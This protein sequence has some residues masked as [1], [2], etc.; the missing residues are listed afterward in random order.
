MKNKIK[1]VSL[2]L[3]LLTLFGCAEKPLQSSGESSLQN[4]EISSTDSISSLDSEATESTESVDENWIKGKENC[5]TFSY[6]KDNY[7][8]TNYYYETGESYD[9]YGYSPY[10]GKTFAEFKAEK[11]GVIVK[12]RVAGDSYNAVLTG[13]SQ[14]FFD[15]SDLETR[16]SVTVGN[17]VN[18]P[19]YFFY[20]L[21]P[22][23]IE[24]IVDD[25]IYGTSIKVGEVVYVME[26]YYK[27]SENVIQI[28]KNNGER[29][30][31]KYE[32]FYG[33]EIA[34]LHEEQWKEKLDLHA[35]LLEN[36]PEG[37]VMGEIAYPMEKDNSYLLFISENH[38]CKAIDEE[39]FK[40]C[41][42]YINFNLSA[43]EPTSYGEKMDAKMNRYKR[44]KEFWE[45][46]KALYGSY[47]E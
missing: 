34:K 42:T 45:E 32:A 40:V 3:S 24:E 7:T 23:I 47:F 26:E 22:V 2:I 9:P 21:T 30:V 4:S 44:Y 6:N 10:D 38:K 17:R 27:I 37:V 14:L 19:Y 5:E 28:I 13:Y 29:E 43:D 1:L 41:K 18:H 35:K 25:G 39:E 8:F 36:H 16:A 20:T 46:A 15:N 12:A 33:G 31:K 11:E